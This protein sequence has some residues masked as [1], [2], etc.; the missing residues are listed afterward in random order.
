MTM[1][2]DGSYRYYFKC[3]DTVEKLFLFSYGKCCLRS[4]STS[5]LILIL[6]KRAVYIQLKS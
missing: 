6:E 4:Y 1:H 2:N 5:S 3:V